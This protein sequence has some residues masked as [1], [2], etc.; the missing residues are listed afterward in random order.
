MDAPL[1]DRPVTGG[2]G[3]EHEAG[4]RCFASLGE[5]LEDLHGGG[6]GEGIRQL[7]GED[8]ADVP[9]VPRDSARAV[10]SGPT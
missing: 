8:Q 9:R 2:D 3:H 6:V 5:A 4:L 10:G 1:I 7:L